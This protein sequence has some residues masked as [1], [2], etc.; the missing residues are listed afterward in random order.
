V[1]NPY[2]IKRAWRIESRR[3][4]LHY[5]TDCFFCLETDIFCLEL[6]HPVTEE[7]DRFYERANCRNCHRK[8][9]IRRDNKGLTHNG[10]RN[11]TE[12]GTEKLKRYLRLMAEDQDYV[13]EH[14]EQSL[15]T[16]TKPIVA[17]YKARAASLRRAANALTLTLEQGSPTIPKKKP[18]AVPHS[19]T[20]VDAGHPSSKT[21]TKAKQS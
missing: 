10:K 19:G 3:K 11:V 5:A 4:Q 12:S 2:P 20:R 17:D 7:L 21:R 9:E 13:A 16:P 8:Q 1:S 18:S 14:L 15:S 6:D